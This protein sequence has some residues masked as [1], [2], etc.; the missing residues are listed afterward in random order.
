MDVCVRL[1][2]MKKKLFECSANLPSIPCLVLSSGIYHVICNL[3][4]E[5]RACGS[6]DT[7]VLTFTFRFLASFLFFCW[8]FSRRHFKGKDFRQAFR[9]L[10]LHKRKGRWVVEQNFRSEFQVNVTCFFAFFSSVLH[11]IVLIVVWFERSLHSAQVSGQSCSWPLKLMTSQ[12]VEGTW[13]R[14]G[15]Y[16]RLRGE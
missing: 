3:T 1:L 10:E 7:A 2:S 11:W 4:N 12:A 13:I 6:S 8:A 14:T 16:G 5:V 15:G 9:I